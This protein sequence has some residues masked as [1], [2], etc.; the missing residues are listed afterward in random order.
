MIDW[1]REEE[2][3]F[4]LSFLESTGLHLWDETHQTL[5]SVAA[6]QFKWLNWLGSGLLQCD[7]LREQ[8]QHAG[9][10]IWYLHIYAYLYLG[11]ESFH[12]R[13]V[14]TGMKTMPNSQLGEFP[15]CS[16]CP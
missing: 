10:N 14:Y 7:C 2:E 16:L 5:P 3:T 15:P 6:Y 9:Y 12:E 13:L 4:F 11:S 8:Q 1:K